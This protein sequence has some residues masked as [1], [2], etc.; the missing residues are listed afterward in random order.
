MGSVL[1]TEDELGMLYIYIKP[2]YIGT[3]DWVTRTVENGDIYIDYDENGEVGGI[4]VLGRV[5]G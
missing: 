4:E 5:I 3:K 2:E 1:I